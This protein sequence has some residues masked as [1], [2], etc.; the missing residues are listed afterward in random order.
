[1]ERGMAFARARFLA[2]SRNP[3]AAMVFGS[4]VEQGATLSAYLAAEMPDNADLPRYQD[5]GPAGPWGI[6]LRALG[7]DTVL[8]EGYGEA[9]EGPILV[10]TVALR[11]Q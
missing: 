1:M 6:A 4:N 7:A 2:I 10:D 8:I 3:L 9:L 11:R 5:G